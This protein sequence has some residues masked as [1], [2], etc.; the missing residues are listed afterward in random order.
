MSDL[1]LLKD[2]NKC[3][4]CLADRRSTHS[5]K[6]SG[7]GVQLFTTTEFELKRYWDEVSR[8]FYCYH[9]EYGWMFSSHLING[10]KPN[11][12]WEKEEQ[13]DNN[14]GKAVTPHEIA[15]MGGKVNSKDILKKFGK[16]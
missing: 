6:C 8:N 2:K 12:R 10:F 11:E 9:N 3:P 5:G 14:Y 1:Y 16:L 13:L 15:G 7:C 4:K